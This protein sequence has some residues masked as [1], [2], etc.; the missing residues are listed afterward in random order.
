VPTKVDIPAQGGMRLFGRGS[1]DDK[2]GIM[3]HIAALEALMKTS[4]SFP[5]N[6]KILFEGEEEIGSV[7]LEEYLQKYLNLLK[8]D[9]LILTD[10]SNYDVGIPSL[11]YSL[12][13]IVSLDVELKTVD[14]TVHSGMWG[15]VL[16]DPLTALCKLLG[17]LHDDHGQI[18]IDHF[19]DGVRQASE[20]EMNCIKSLGYNEEKLRKE[21]GLLADVKVIGDPNKS[22]LE[23]N[24]V[25]TCAKCHSIRCLHIKCCCE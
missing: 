19:Y 12:R 16:M 10:T 22:I 18:A 20:K 21:S 2:A 1:A 15:G 4:S 6:V 9:I 8:A 14:H 17:T 25:T 5:I 13:G 24:L 11:T 7:H 23:K 3:V